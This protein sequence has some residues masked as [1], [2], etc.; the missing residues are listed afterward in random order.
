MIQV[1]NQENLLLPLSTVRPS[2]IRLG[3]HPYDTI[4]SR[5]R[6]NTL[7][8]YEVDLIWVWGGWGA[9]IIT[10]IMIQV[11]NQENLLL[12][13]WLL[14]LRPSIYQAEVASV[15]LQAT[16]G[17]AETHYICISRSDMSKKWAGGVK[18]GIPCQ[19][20]IQSLLSLPLSEEI[21]VWTV[22]FASIW[23]PQ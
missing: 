22:A 17:D 2:I 10:Y 4:H 14:T 20:L 18:R 6:W 21:S 13:P 7:Y 5:Q 23:L 16:V 1:R 3:L 9:T 19:K 12:P 11:R 15:R 8:M